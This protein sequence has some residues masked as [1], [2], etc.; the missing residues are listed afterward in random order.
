MRRS[1]TC[2]RL[3]GM[4]VCIAQPTQERCRNNPQRM[5]QQL[6]RY[7]RFYLLPPEEPP[8]EPR[9][10]LR[11]PK[12]PPEEPPLEPLRARL[13]PPEEPPDEPPLEPLRAR[14]T[15]PEE[16]PRERAREPPLEPPLELETAPPEEPP[17]E[18]PRRPAASALS[19]MH[20]IAK[21]LKQISAIESRFIGKILSRTC[22]TNHMHH[23]IESETFH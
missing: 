7:Q 1:L 5:S 11:P 8:L 6:S 12:E 15:P 20:T 9:A 3:L 14:L 10:R 13:S 22:S 19:V 21:T 4:S 2:R 18:P 23:S 16:P 17:L